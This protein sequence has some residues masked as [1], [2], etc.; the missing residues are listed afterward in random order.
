MRSDT[1][2]LDEGFS[3]PDLQHRAPTDDLQI[4]N[5]SGPA[6][7]SGLFRPGV[8]MRHG[9]PHLRP[10]R[11]GRLFSQVGCT[12]SQTCLAYRGREQAFERTQRVHEPLTA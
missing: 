11:Q 5:F 8:R 7:P 2:R 6:L 12:V 10:T 1:Q 4:G 9:N 3:I